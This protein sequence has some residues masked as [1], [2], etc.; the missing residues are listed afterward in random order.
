MRNV[1][2]SIDEQVLSQARKRATLKGTTLNEEVRTWMNQ[3]ATPITSKRF[4]EIMQ[5]VSYVRTDRKYTREEMN[6][7]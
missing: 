5:Q 2:F 6:D 7:R 1:T 3:Y 4:K